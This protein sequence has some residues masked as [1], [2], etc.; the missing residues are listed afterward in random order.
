MKEKRYSEEQIVGI[1][2]EHD[3]GAKVAALV[4]RQG[5]SDAQNFYRWKSKFGIMGVSEAK[6]QRKLESK[7]ARLKKL[8][9]EAEPEQ[10][11]S[12]M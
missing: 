5:I 10:P 12:G 9:A 3:V 6:R 11:C 8:L 7:N 1:L 2:K 4:R